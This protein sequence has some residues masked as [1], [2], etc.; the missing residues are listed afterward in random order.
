MRCKHCKEKFDPR[1]FNQ[2]YCFKSECVKE[3][4]EK[5]KAENWRKLKKR[6]KSELETT[7]SL[8]KKCQTY[9]N[10]YIRLRDKN[11]PCISCGSKLGKV[12]D[13]GHFWSAGGF[14][15]VRFDLDNIAGQCRKCN[16]YLHG[17][18]IGYQ[19]GLINRIGKDRFNQLKQRAYEQ[20]K[21]SRDEL[22]EMIEWFKG[23]IKRLQEK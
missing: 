3:W 5:S 12:Y 7:Q 21:Y 9:C 17:N 14:Y 13:A 19:E 10:K 6:L 2:K 11:R 4:V 22:R 15:S 23:E 8:I 16:R 18:L 1:H 20:R